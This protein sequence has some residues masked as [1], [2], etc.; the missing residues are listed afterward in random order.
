MSKKDNAHV[1]VVTGLR[2]CGKTFLLK[3][4]YAQWLESNGVS[5]ENII[6]L[7]LDKNENAK[8]RNPLILDEYLKNII[9]KNK[10]PQKLVCQNL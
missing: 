3:E 8:F 5:K 4:L 1:K 7:A 6:Y 2:R 9:K 10:L